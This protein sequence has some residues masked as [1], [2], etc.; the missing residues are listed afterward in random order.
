MIPVGIRVHQLT[1]G[2]GSGEMDTGHRRRAMICRKF[3]LGY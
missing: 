2:K 1:R 3:W